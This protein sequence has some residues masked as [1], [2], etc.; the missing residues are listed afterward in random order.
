MFHHAR[1]DQSGDY[2]SSQLLDLLAFGP[3]LAK[4]MHTQ[5]RAV[6]VD[7]LIEVVSEEDVKDMLSGMFISTFD[8]HRVCR[9]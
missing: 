7:R 2:D 4:R 6:D 5:V 8:F 9:Y 1:I 3:D